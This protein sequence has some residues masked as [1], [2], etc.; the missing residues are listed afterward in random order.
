MKLHELKIKREYFNA[1]KSGEK[2]FEIRKNDRDF[3]VGDIVNFTVVEE[4]SVDSGYEA[5]ELS[6]AGFTVTPSSSIED[7]LARGYKAVK[8][9]IDKDV[10]V[11][12]YVLKNIPEYGLDKDYCI[13]GI[14]RLQ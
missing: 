2:T 3:Q 7:S 5:S 12:T 4:K 8:K 6:R 10:Y 1:I 14:R 13:F 9:E 11:I